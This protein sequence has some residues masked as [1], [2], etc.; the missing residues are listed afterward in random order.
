MFDNVIQY[1]YLV[2]IFSMLI[3]T[4][5]FGINHWDITTL[6]NQLMTNLKKLQILCSTILLETMVLSVICGIIIV[7][8]D[9]ATKFIDAS[10]KLNIE[11]I[12][13]FLIALVILSLILSVSFHLL[14]L[15]GKKI[16]FVRTVYFINLPDS[17]EKWYLERRSN[18]SEI[19]ISNSKEEYLFLSGWG[20]LVFKSELAPLNQFQRIIFS[21][22][23]KYN[24]IFITLLTSIVVLYVIFVFVNKNLNTVEA[25]VILF[26]IV[27]LFILCR[28]LE[29]AKE[30]IFKQN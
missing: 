13:P 21:S 5:T 20:N 24:K 14:M 18:K 26:T 11:R 22:E 17:E 6:E 23:K 2:P 4:I 12:P 9:G 25:F 15:L 30:I 3:V 29:R 8:S 10:G 19:L 7:V 16:I 1:Y 27:F 28:W